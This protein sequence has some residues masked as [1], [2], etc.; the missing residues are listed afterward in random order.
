MLAHTDIKDKVD[1][2]LIL[3]GILAI[4]ADVLKREFCAFSLSIKT[5]E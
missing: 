1:A 4:I 2:E 5:I 3:D